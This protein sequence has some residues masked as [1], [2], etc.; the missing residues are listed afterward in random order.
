[1]RP[2]TRPARRRAIA[3]AVAVAALA[4]GYASASAAPSRGGARRISFGHS[5]RGAPLRAVR[6]GDPNADRTALVV[7]SIH[8][9]ETA[10]EK[11]IRI[12][13]H[14]YRHV[15]GVALWTVKTVNPDGVAAGTRRDARGVD[16]NRNFPYRWRGGVPAASG[17]YPGPRPASEPET[18]AAMRLV[19]RIRPDL[20]IWYHQPWGQVLLPCRRPARVQRRYARIARWPAKRC[21]GA[22][23]PGTAIS[24][25]NHR[26]GGTAFVVELGSRA[27]SDAEAR[28]QARAVVRV[29]AGRH[30]GGRSPA[31]GARGGAG[32]VRRPRIDR[33]PIPYGKQR[34]RE[35][36]AYS[37]R[38]YG[39]RAWRL[40]NP[41]V[42]VLHFT[43]GPTYR[44]AWSTFAS[45]APN[46]GE[47]PGVC[48]QYVIGKNGAIHELVRP[49]VRCR[50]TI[51]LN[52]TAIGIEMVQEQGPSS[53]WADQQILGRRPQIRAAL[54]LVAWLK[55]RYGI[56]TDD[57]IGHAMANHSPYFKDLEGWHDDHTDW[58]HRDVV[59]FR[60]R[61]R[62][63]PGSGRVLR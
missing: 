37:A 52:Y 31:L 45:N 36:A 13:R 2:I 50:H 61:L 49:T 11:V 60:R 29:A 42:I 10:G 22:H 54:H 26:V 58:L 27:L 23:L 57:V 32:E 38:H 17:Y 14:R 1:M 3:G 9:D 39:H 41:H 44:S 53:H 48:S 5:V 12:L 47:L 34:K 25:Q 7:G 40:R 8:G 18:R 20:S 59:V 55:Q 56:A 63:V 19:R 46:L 21:R 51:G 43:A 28:R 62:S 4:A 30:R 15:R 24:W 6:I 16:L 33:D 35:M